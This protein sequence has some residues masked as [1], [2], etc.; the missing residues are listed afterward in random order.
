MLPA[1]GPAA[2]AAA[3]AAGDAVDDAEPITFHTRMFQI[4]VERS[5]IVGGE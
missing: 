3:N 1:H 5:S 2:S 4:P